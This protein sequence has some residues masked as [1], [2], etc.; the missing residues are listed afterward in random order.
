MLQYKVFEHP[1]NLTQWV[2]DNPSSITVHSV[3]LDEF[4]KYILFYSS[5]NDSGAPEEF[6]AEALYEQLRFG[7]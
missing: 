2:N 7:N 6:D 5:T 1:V 4:G 3:V